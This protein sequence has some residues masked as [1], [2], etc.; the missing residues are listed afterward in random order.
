MTTRCYLHFLGLTL[1]A[2]SLLWAQPELESVAALQRDAWQQITAK[3]PEIAANAVQEFYLE[4]APDL[5]KE[6]DRFCLDRPNEAVLF[7]QRM[8][9]KFLAIQRV[10]DVNPQEYQRLLAMQ[11]LESQI[12]ISSKDVQ[13][14]AEQLEGKKATEEPKLYWELQQQKQEL[15]RLLKE[16]FEESQQH[17]QIEIRRLE[18]EMTM[19]KQR[20]QERS[21]NQEMI[22]QERFRVLT[23]MNLTAEEQ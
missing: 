2:C 9:D 7:L 22:L 18:A 3:Y 20:F 11:K 13:N 21:A 16:S 17:Q 1:L 19:L 23:G 8:I 10:K 6:W 14:L 12:R 5:L 4:Y 15:M